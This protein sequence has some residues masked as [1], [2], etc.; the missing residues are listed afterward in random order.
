MVQAVRGA[1]IVAPRRTR[2][3]DA[4]RVH[5]GQFARW[6]Q[7]EGQDGG[8]VLNR[9][10]MF[11]L[12]GFIDLHVHFDE[13]GR[14]DWEGV[15]NGS[16]KSV[17]GGVTTVVDMPI[18]SDPPTIAARDVA[19]KCEIFLAKSFSNFAVLAGAVPGRLAEMREAAL[20]GAAGFKGF[21]CDSGWDDFPP[22]D[23]ESLREALLNASR[24]GLRLAL[25]AEDQSQ[26]V[27]DQIGDLGRPVSSEV[28]AVSTI[29]TLAGELGAKVHLVHLST[30]EAVRM[31]NNSPLATSETCPH[32]F[33]SDEVLVRFELNDVV[34][35][36]PVRSSSL[37]NELRE[38]VQN[39][40]LDA[41]GSDHSPGPPNSDSFSGQWR[42]AQGAGKTMLA[43][44]DEFDSPELVADYTA[45]AASVYGFTGSGEISVGGQ[46]DFVV[47]ERSDN[48]LWRIVDV[49]VGGR[50]VVKDST[51]IGRPVVRNAFSRTI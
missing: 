6:D 7:C 46:A 47:A 17:L 48:G 43:L 44:L 5:N 25:H 31:V 20:A 30:P 38:L 10:G 19:E 49:V 4:L 51:V 28:S 34:V 15:E 36:P 33:S 14:T 32:Y 9:D 24:I 37:R 12:P 29:L 50:L 42:G 39:G 45:S 27:S 40:W 18:D 8:V 11:V 35:S 21:L 3:G 41:V 2:W 26:F 13:P 16:L 1:T 23:G 22:L